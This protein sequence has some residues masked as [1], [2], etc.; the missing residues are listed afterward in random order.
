MKKL[1]A[2]LLAMTLCMGLVAC[3][4]SQS[5]VES[6]YDSS[7]VSVSEPGEQSASEPTVESVR[8][9]EREEASEPVSE[10]TEKPSEKPEKTEKP[11]QSEPAEPTVQPTLVPSAAPSTQ[12]T[13]APTPVKTPAAQP[14][15]APTPTSTPT[16]APTSTPTPT[17]APS[18]GAKTQA[19]LSA[20]IDQILVGTDE[21]NSGD[22][23]EIPKDND[24]WNYHLYIDYVD[25]YEAVAYAPQINVIAYFMA[26]VS[27]PENVDANAIAANMKAKADLNKWVCVGADQMDAVVNGNVILFYM[28]DSERFPNSAAKLTENFKNAGI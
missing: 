3:A 27:V 13:P 17:P 18:A 23:W 15:A 11:E 16:P 21:V 20:L 2:L 28:M 22:K 8:E 26:L 4:S 25:G 7:S 5:N 10:K 24:S 1:I 14:T 12:P 6:A 19:E 9:P